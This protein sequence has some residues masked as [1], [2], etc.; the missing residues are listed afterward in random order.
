[1]DTAAAVDAHAT[2]W[3]PSSPSLLPFCPFVFHP[4]F[5]DAMQAWAR[6]S[7]TTLGRPS[8]W[9]TSLITGMLVSPAASLGLCLVSSCHIQQVKNA[10][11]RLKLVCCIRPRTINQLLLIAV[12]GRN[13]PYANTRLTECQKA[14]HWHTGLNPNP[15]NLTNLNPPTLF[16]HSC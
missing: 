13:S 2:P 15:N 11:A 1:M 3:P 5:P 14:T 6:R 10:G 9:M 4:T 8:S 16:A 12:A 7:Q